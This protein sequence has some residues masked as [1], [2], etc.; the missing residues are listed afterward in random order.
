MLRIF[1]FMKLKDAAKSEL[2]VDPGIMSP[3]IDGSHFSS[4]LGRNS[5][6]I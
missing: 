6:Q 5:F 1:L 4:T 3:F 2:S